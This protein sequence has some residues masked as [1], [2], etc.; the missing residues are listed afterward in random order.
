MNKL[1]SLSLLFCNIV[2][3]F[4][5]LWIQ[6]MYK[7]PQFFLYCQGFVKRIISDGLVH[8]FYVGWIISF[9]LHFS[10]SFLKSGAQSSIASKKP[11]LCLVSLFG[12]CL[13]PN[14]WVLSGYV[15]RYL[16]RQSKIYRR[17][18]GISGFPW[19]QPITSIAKDLWNGYSETIYLYFVVRLGLSVCTK[20]KLHLCRK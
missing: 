13:I 15:L 3:S 12:L 19:I 8:D 17:V 14:A 2:L 5:T 20:C 1:I 10:R 7:R 16:P 11:G 18:G 9:F 6:R 4:C